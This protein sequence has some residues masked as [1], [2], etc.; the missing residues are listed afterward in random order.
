[1]TAVSRKTRTGFGARLN[2]FS[3]LTSLVDEEF[4]EEL[5]NADHE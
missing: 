1:M 3:L 4:F 5:K 2:A